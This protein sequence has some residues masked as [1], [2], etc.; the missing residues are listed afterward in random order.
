VNPVAAVHVRPSIDQAIVLVPPAIHRLFPYVTAYPVGV[1]KVDAIPVHVVPSTEYAIV[2]VPVPT[3]TYNNPFHA[4]LYAAVE[5]IVVPSPVHA[6]PSKEYA[7]VFVP[8]PT[9]TQKSSPNTALYP[10]VLK[11]VVPNPVHVSP[12]SFEYAIVLVPSPYAR[13][14]LLD[15]ALV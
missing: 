4:T 3:A 15:E 10:P 11:I 12:S 5:K 8:A 14:K 9:A 2:F 6:V 7:S 13:I 1:I